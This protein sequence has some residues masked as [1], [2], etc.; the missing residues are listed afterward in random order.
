M[1]PL[2]VALPLVLIPFS[3][4]VATLVWMARSAR[5]AGVRA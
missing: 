4:F 5:P 2:A 3:G 1:L